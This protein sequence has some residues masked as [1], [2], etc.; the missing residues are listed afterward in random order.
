[1]YVF[2]VPTIHHDTRLLTGR[3]TLADPS[4]RKYRSSHEWVKL[5]GEVATV[6]ISDHAQAALGDIVFADLPEIGASA[7]SGEPAATVES[8]KAAADI[9]APIDGEVVNVNKNLEETPDLI[10][11]APHDDGWI[12][13]VKVSDSS[14]LDALMDSED[15]EKTLEE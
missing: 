3:S 6:G 11:S 9:Y 7:V 12:F 5:D 4:D 8:V 10:N 13:Q 14:Q 1:M 15:Y 2:R